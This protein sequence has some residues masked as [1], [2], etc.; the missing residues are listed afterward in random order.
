[1]LATLAFSSACGD[2]NVTDNSSAGAQADSNATVDTAV[3]G[4]S[5]G[6]DAAS[7]DQT[8]GDQSGGDTGTDKDTLIADG[9]DSDGTTSDGTDTDG[10]DSDVAADGTDSDAGDT[11]PGD[12]GDTSTTCKPTEPPAEVCD[13]IDNDC[14]GQTDEATCS[15]ANPC[16]VDLC[17]AV[18]PTTPDTTCSHQPK[19][20]PCSDGNA[21]TQDDICTGGTC[22]G[23]AVQCDDKN[24]CTDDACDQA[25]GC[26]ATDNTAACDD[27]NPCS[28]AEACAGGKCQGGSAKV[29][30]DG[31]PCTK[32]ACDIASGCT[33][34]AEDGGSCDDGDKCT[35]GE[36]CAAGKCANGAAVLC[37][38]QNPCTNDACDMAAGCTATIAANSCDDG[39]KC[40][41]GDH[42]EIGKCT[43]GDAVTCDDN[44]PCTTD[45]C[46][47]ASGCTNTANTLECDDGSACTAGDVCASGKCQAGQALVCDDGNPC[48]TDSCDLASGCTAVVA[49]G[50]GCSDGNACTEGDSCTAG[51][52]AAGAAK[53][54]DDGNACTKDA[55][56]VAVG[57]TATATTDPCDDGDACTSNDA[58]AGGNCAPGA[59]VSCDDNNPCTVD[60]CDKQQGCIFK[61]TSAAC[62][63]GDVCTTT[64][65]CV[66]GT[67]TGGDLKVCDDGEACTADKCDAKLGCIT[68]NLDVACDDGTACTKDDK[69]VS[70]KCQSGDKVVCDDG[71]AC[72]D[73]KCDAKVGCVVTANSAKCDDGSAC[74][75]GDACNGGKCEGGA[76]LVCDDKNP[77][78]DDLCDIAK[79]CVYVNNDENACTDGTVCTKGDACKAGKC[80]VGAK[81][82]CNDNNVCTDDSCDAV[83][84]CVN[85]FN[86]AGCDD[87][88]AC[89][90]GDKCSSGKCVA[91]GGVICDDKNACTKDS[92]DAATSKCIYTPVANAPCDD[93]N[94]CTVGDACDGTGKCALTKPQVC[95]DGKGCTTDS[96]DPTKG[97]VFAAVDQ[98][99]TLPHASA[100]TCNEPAL[101]LWSLDKPVGTLGWKVDALPNPPGFKS[102]NCS[103]NFNNDK[104]FACATGAT[105]VAAAFAVSPRLDATQVKAG[106][107]V[108]VNFALNGGWEFGAFDNLRLEFTVDD[109]K[110]WVLAKDFDPW[111]TSYPPV[112][113]WN[114]VSL[115]LPSAVVGKVF[116]VRFAF[117]TTDCIG[118]E[119]AGAF[120]DDFK[121]TT[122]LCSDNA[123]CDDGNTCTTDSCTKSGTCQW[124]AN[125]LGCDD[126]TVCDGK[127]LCTS[128]FC[129]PGTALLNCNDN[130]PCT[131]DSC[132]PKLGCQWK[133]NVAPCTDGNACTDKDVCKDGKC[134]VGAPLVCDDKSTCTTDACDPAKGCSYTPKLGSGVAVCDGK[135]IGGSCIKLNKSA[136]A[137]TWV[138][139]QA[140]CKTWGGELVKI[141][142]GTKNDAVLAYQKSLNGGTFAGYWIGLSDVAAE[143]TWVW[144]DGSK[145]TY[146]NWDAGQP[147]NANNEDYVHVW[148]AAGKWNDLLPGNPGFTPLWYACE[149]PMQ[150]TCSD[151][152]ACTSGDLCAA[153]GT[154]AGATP[155]KCDDG[156]V[157][158]LDSCDPTKGCVAANLKDGTACD[159]GNACTASEI[160]TTGKCGTGKLVAC[161]DGKPC[162]DDSCVAPGGCVYKV[163]ANAGTPPCDGTLIGGV[164]YKAFTNDLTWGNAQTACKNWGG[165]LAT[166][167]SGNQAAVHTYASSVCTVGDAYAIGLSDAAAEGKYAWLDGSAYVYSNWNA[168]EPNN[169]GDEDYVGVYV[170]AGSG[171]GKWNDTTGVYVYGCYMC[172]RPDVV[173]CNDGNACTAAEWCGATGDCANGKTVVCDDNNA[174][175]LDTCDKL[176]GCV[177]TPVL[178]GTKCT[179]GDL[180][181]TTDACA[182]GSCKPG[183][184][185]NCDDAKE[186]TLDSCDKATGCVHKTKAGSGVPLCDGKDIGG[187]CVKFT[188][189]A[190][191]I[192]W[193]GAQT[194]CKAWGGNLVKIGD[195]AKNDAVLAYQK[196]LNANVFASY[197]IGL[198][199]VATEGTYLWQDGSKAT[200]FNWDVSQPDNAGNTE[201]YV[202]VYTAAG[203][204]NDLSVSVP[205]FP[206]SWYAC[207]RGMPVTCNDGTACT[208][209]EYCDANGACGN[210]S[211]VTCNDSSA[212][213]TDSC[214]KVTGCKYTPVVCNDNNACTTDTCDIATGCKYTPAPTTEDKCT[215]TKSPKSAGSCDPCVQSICKADPFCCT[216]AWDSKCVY[217]VATICK[218]ANC[219]GSVAATGTCGHGLCL[220]GVKLVSGCDPAPAGTGC[221][222]KICATDPFCCN[223]SWD[224]QCV[225]EVKTICALTCQ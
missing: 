127:D 31:N 109:G 187:S 174:C 202:H 6:T 195:Q 186:C 61:A 50:T 169:S 173:T 131:D 125:T 172:Q 51:K 27:G 142:D 98:C 106:T 32:D 150:L 85:A 81:I 88:N 117:N 177:Y 119:L 13:G 116:R 210:G 25:S 24:P 221:V 3:L 62:D 5:A 37:D 212:C 42:C 222:A 218:V 191:P 166:I 70:G 220:T 78:T 114:N 83:K 165:N 2:G 199:D 68:A 14:N 7:A 47:M 213:T 188:K 211:A 128:G 97:C 121:V 17:G 153:N 101:A 179:D 184:A 132:D 76:K 92:C 43:G 26:T 105:A 107:P 104:D 155:V 59:K 215:V 84:G 151:G 19:D 224:G 71:N 110:N 60:I 189:A 40:T 141:T 207:E 164:C 108:V 21:C 45:A 29:C 94:P 214:D 223:T 75:T 30:D 197:W 124:T 63:D 55:C 18:S 203:K 65:K 8:G 219:T 162:T 64:D 183:A 190:A 48:S 148:T 139:A 135:D 225:T 145:S 35:T 86:L 129:K 58:C 112:Q 181:T 74:T 130:N 90:T 46:D 143:G 22:G 206:I 182:A 41:S 163:K 69:C 192:N 209:G 79:G 72:T 115:A 102:A 167:T 204:W 154:C 137:I 33:A 93:A 34:T 52:C 157:C 120:I 10:T 180:C 96:C 87:G 205:G 170:Y 56:D 185:L 158:T 23:K 144:T 15:D 126:G 73:D 194:A 208:T 66:D 57:C 140:A 80:E 54:C 39:N 103:L 11:A 171:N 216:N 160:C 136:A 113:T 168:G 28:T 123:Q 67:C 217:E 178:D 44:N 111:G 82:D 4:D 198:T 156:N 38:D 176:K 89:S 134:V 147:D 100:F 9:T 200:W 122:G 20:G 193:T 149:R 12:G 49:N 99:V 36:T 159:D 201:D 77:C 118:N 133:A 152:N 146:F 16:T 138:N 175:T 1:M 91:T 95:D 196:S 53:T 161:D